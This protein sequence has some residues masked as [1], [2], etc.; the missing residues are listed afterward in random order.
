MERENVSK[1]TELSSMAKGVPD[2][3][4][5]MILGGHGEQWG[6]TSRWRDYHFAPC[7]F[8]RRSNRD[9]QGGVVNMTVSP[10]AR[11]D[12]RHVRSRADNLAPVRDVQHVRHAKRSACDCKTTAE[13]CL[14]LLAIAGW[15]PWLNGSGPLEWSTTR[16]TRMTASGNSAACSTGGASRR[17][18]W[19]IRWRGP[20]RQALAAACG[21]SAH[22]L[23]VS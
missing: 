18:R 3:L 11:R 21:S 17:R 10:T 15:P 14:C 8:I 4:C 6:E 22:W 7:A 23:G 16:L 13:W 9:K 19:T 5:P 12:R 20:R 1:M 2:E